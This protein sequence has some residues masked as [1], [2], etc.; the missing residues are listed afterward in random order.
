MTTDDDTPPAP[1]RMNWGD[2]IR[3]IREGQ[4]LSQRRLAKLADVDRASN[5]HWLF[6]RFNKR[7]STT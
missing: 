6:G 1:S 3:K 7:W 4:G 2:E 5:K